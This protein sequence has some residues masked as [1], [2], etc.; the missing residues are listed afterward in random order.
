MS[1]LTSSAEKGMFMEKSVIGAMIM[2]Q[3]KLLENAQHRVVVELC[4]S[5]LDMMRFIE[6]RLTVDRA[7]M[8]AIPS[9]AAVRAID[10]VFHDFELRLQNVFEQMDKDTEQLVAAYADK[11][12]FE[13]AY[14][15]SVQRAELTKRKWLGQCKAAQFFEEA[16]KHAAANANACDRILALRKRIQSHEATLRHGQEKIMGLIEEFIE[17]YQDKEKSVAEVS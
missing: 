11:E 7:M 12:D 3:E 5:R 4:G 16:A 1:E 10:E 15:E 8:R 17:R 13:S 2:A 6:Q 14:Q 9:K